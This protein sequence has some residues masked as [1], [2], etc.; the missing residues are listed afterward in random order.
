MSD[1]ATAT[2]LE[3]QGDVRPV[4]HG[5]DSRFLVEFY[6]R[7][8]EDER[9]TRLRGRRFLKPVPYCRK[10]A[11]GDPRTVWDAPVSESDKLR[12]PQQWMAYERGE[13]DMAI[14]TPLDSWPLLSREARILLKN[15]GFKT[16]EQ[17]TEVTDGTLLGMD[18]EISRVIAQVREHAKKFITDQQSGEAERKLAQELEERDNQIGAL[19]NQIAQLSAT[20][21]RMNAERLAA[22]I[23]RPQE[24]GPGFQ[25]PPPPE[26]S[27]ETQGL[28]DLEAL[29]A[30]EPLPDEEDLTP[31][32]GKAAPATL[33][34]PGPLKR[35]L[36]DE[37]IAEIRQSQDSNKAL[38]EQYGVSVPTIAKYRKP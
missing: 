35:K 32:P 33:P 10:R 6:T 19:Q 7:E 3:G 21:E 24:T 22:P 1:F 17:I 8:V 15:W 26:K 27:V 36:S 25:P 12:W 37:Q 11:M 18:K 31:D 16:V 28:A 13:H 5:D 38:A 14:G 23:V 34:G 29:P 9:E 4:Q 30:L 2:V 20:V